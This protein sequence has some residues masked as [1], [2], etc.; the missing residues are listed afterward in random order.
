[1]GLRACPFIGP[2]GELPDRAV[3]ALHAGYLDGRASE[4]KVELR[5]FDRL[6]ECGA[7]ITEAD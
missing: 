3:C 6:N 2:D 7:R 5:P 4:L 1:M